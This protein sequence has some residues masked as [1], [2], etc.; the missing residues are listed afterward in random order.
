MWMAGGM[1]DSIDSGRVVV[2]SA[3]GANFCESKLNNYKSRL[4][5]E[6]Q[7]Y[8]ENLRVLREQIDLE[9]NQ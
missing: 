8:L 3:E 9:L 1:A 2:V 6:R 7:N 5:G 4:E